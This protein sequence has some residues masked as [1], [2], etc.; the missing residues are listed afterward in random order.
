MHVARPQGR[1]A[2]V[3]LRAASLTGRSA[4]TLDAAMCVPSLSGSGPIDRRMAIGSGEAARKVCH[5]PRIG[6]HCGKRITDQRRAEMQSDAGARQW[7]GGAH[8]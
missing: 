8:V 2:K 4:L 6:I 7:P 1:K 3:G 5:H